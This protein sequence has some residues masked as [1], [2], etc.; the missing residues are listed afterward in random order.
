MRCAYKKSIERAAAHPFRAQ[1]VAI[2]AI[3]LSALA[4]RGTRYSRSRYAE[5]CGVLT[6]PNQKTPSS[7]SC[8]A[9]HW[10]VP[11]NL[12]GVA[13]PAH[14]YPA[15]HT[16]S[17]ALISTMGVRRTPRERSKARRRAQRST[18]NA[19]T[20]LTTFIRFSLGFDDVP[21]LEEPAWWH[22]NWIEIQAGAHKLQ[23]ACVPGWVRLLTWPPPA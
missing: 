5:N 20:A 19:H 22:G 6:F 7:S 23:A 21:S 9:P 3:V 2:A 8:F 12:E 10:G 15:H 13:A 16:A 17:C 14:H 11:S 1:C 18:F 4:H